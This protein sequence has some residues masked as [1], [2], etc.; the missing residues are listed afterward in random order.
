LTVLSTDSEF[1]PA[2]LPPQQVAI[3]RTPPYMALYDWW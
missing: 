2:H 3:L 1:E